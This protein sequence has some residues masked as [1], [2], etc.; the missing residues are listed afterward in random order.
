MNEE[1]ALIVE[2]DRRLATV[3]AQALQTAGFAIEKIYDG[4]KALER[5][6]EIAPSILLL[7]LHLPQARDLG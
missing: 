7:D 1:T 4:Q 5:L 2:D 3:F 6:E